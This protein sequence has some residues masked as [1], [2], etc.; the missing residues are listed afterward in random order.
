MNP[1][2]RLESLLQRAAQTHPPATAPLATG[3]SLLERLTDAA[4]RAVLQQRNKELS[5]EADASKKRPAS[6]GVPVGAPG[7]GGGGGG[8]SGKKMVQSKLFFPRVVASQSS[9][10]AADHLKKPVAAPLAEDAVIV[11]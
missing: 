4:V 10:P 3:E 1:Q 7:G 11:D 5:A 6:G 8:S 9:A 2:E